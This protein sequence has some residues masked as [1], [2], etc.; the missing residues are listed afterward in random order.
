MPEVA[1]VWRRSGPADVARFGEGLLPSHRRAMDDLVH[2]RTETLGGHLLPCE[3]CGQEHDVYHACR[4][5]RCPTCH[6][7][8]TE[9]WRAER[10]Q[11]LL[12]VTS[13][14][15]VFTVPHELGEIIH[16]QHK[17]LDASLLRA[18]A[19]ARIKR[20]ADPHD[21]GGLMG[22]LCVLHTWTR[23]LA[24]HPHGHCLV[25]AGGVS[26]ERTAWRPAPTSDLVPVHALSKRLRGLF[27]ALVRQDRPDLTRPEAVG[28]TGWVI[29]CTPTVQGTAQ[30]VP[31]LGRSVHRIAR[32]HPRLLSIA[33][34]QVGVRSQDAPS[35][36]WH[37]LTLP[38]QECIRRFLPHVWPQGFHK[39]RY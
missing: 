16:Q 30:V 33:D 5:R 28:T 25:P 9:A 37:T 13:V 2:C 10:R 34:G 29:S 19:H 26:A 39:V 7:Q 1:D 38:A 36:R 8:D 21:V 31:Y 6:R 20:A 11:E 32:T 12:P 4:H 15:L 17:D 27:L 22:V 35:Y 14:H 23:T 3:P 24:S 18:A